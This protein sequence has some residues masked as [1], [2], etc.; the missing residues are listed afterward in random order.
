MTNSITTKCRWR[1]YSGIRI[2]VPGWRTSVEI[3]G[4]SRFSSSK[5]MHACVWQRADGL[6]AAYYERHVPGTT[7]DVELPVADT[8]REAKRAAEQALLGYVKQL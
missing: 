4:S 1:R 3:P 2:E 6:W 7:I 5:K 8:E